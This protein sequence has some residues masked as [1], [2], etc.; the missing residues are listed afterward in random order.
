VAYLTFGRGARLITG[1]QPLF[2]DLK[3]PKDRAGALTREHGAEPVA[4]RQ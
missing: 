3:M 1:L 2:E 4:P